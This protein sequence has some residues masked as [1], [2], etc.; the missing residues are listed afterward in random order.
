MN[1]NGTE[2]QNSNIE[3]TITPQFINETSPTPVPLANNDS[4]VE[5]IPTTVVDVNPT[6]MQVSNT[7][8][9]EEV[10]VDNSI[11]SASNS[12]EPTVINTSKKKTSSIIV[13]VFVILLIAFVLN[14]DKV[15][16]YYEQYM[17]TGTLINNNSASNNNLI[18][19][20]L[21]I[22]DSSTNIKVSDIRF[23]NFRKSNNNAIT[24]NYESSTKYNESSNLNIYIELYNSNKEL[25]Y[26]ELF[27]TE[28]IIEKDT[29]RIYTMMLDSYVYQN[30][31]YGLVKV[32]TEEEKNSKSTLICKFEETTDGVTAKYQ[33]T[34]NFINDSLTSYDVNKTIENNNLLNQYYIDLSSENTEV[35]NYVTTNFSPLG[36]SYSVDLTNKIE[37][38]IPL[39]NE[40]TTPVVIKNKEILKKWNCE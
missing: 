28:N 40:N 18:N 23:Y 9:T 21:Q 31:F 36:L 37:E 1:N 17:S 12:S 14:I 22:D 39:Y 30:A 32:Y 27:N 11:P 33:I 19:G 7:N 38:F 2:N 29:V 13:I 34:Y 15:I 8:I 10:V 16:E 26:K 24:F 3:Q 4:V 25:L 20:F 6:N 5:P 35:S